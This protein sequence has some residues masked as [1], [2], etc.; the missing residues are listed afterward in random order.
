MVNTADQKIYPYF[1]WEGISSEL[2]FTTTP[3]GMEGYFIQTDSTISFLEYTLTRLGLN[4]T[5]MTDFITFWGPQIEKHQYATIQ[6]LVDE[7]YTNEIAGINVNPAPDA[8]LRIYLLFEGSE[9]ELKQNF[10][11]TPLLNPF[12]RKGL[13]L[14]EWGGSEI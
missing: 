2:G 7:V 5:E 4:Q 14:V 10:L 6:F 13:T 1:F 3:T 9:I 8:M 12:V 11:N